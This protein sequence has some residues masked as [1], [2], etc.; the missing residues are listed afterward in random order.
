MYGAI[1]CN[2]N[3]CYSCSLCAIKNS[4]LAVA[5]HRNSD[6]N[7]ILQQWLTKNS[8]LKLEFICKIVCSLVLIYSRVASSEAESCWR[9]EHSRELVASGEAAS[10]ELCNLY[11]LSYTC[12]GGVE[13]GVE[14]G[15][16]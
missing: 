16:G 11:K 7:P 8:I 15:E 13:V 1:Y 5:Y 2:V 3:V 6:Q 9:V 14:M 10:K 12:D 4:T